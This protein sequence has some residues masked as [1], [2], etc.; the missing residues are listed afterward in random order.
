MGGETNY[1]MDTR[2]QPQ[3]LIPIHG[4][5]DQ[6][7]PYEHIKNAFPVEDGDHL[8]VLKK[9]DVVSSILSGIL[10]MKEDE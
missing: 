3:K 9:A 2:R 4:T 6:I 8:M 1:G 7:F 5:L 10:L